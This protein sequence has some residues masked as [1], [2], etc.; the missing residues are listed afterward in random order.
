MTVVMKISRV[1]LELLVQDAEEAPHDGQVAEQR[2]LGDL[3]GGAIAAQA[4][5]TTVSS[6][7]HAQFGLCMPFGLF[8]NGRYLA[9]G[10]DVSHDEGTVLRVD[11]QVDVPSSLMRGRTV[12]MVPTSTNSTRL[13]LLILLRLLLVLPKLPPKMVVEET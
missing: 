11:L 13:V 10:E 1:L 12:R 2:C 6:G 7:I 5:R 3:P 4:S 8:R 9:I